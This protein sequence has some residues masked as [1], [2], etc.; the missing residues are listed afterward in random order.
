ME[1]EQKSEPLILWWNSDSG[2]FE[3]TKSK[4]TEGVFLEMNDENRL[5]LFSYSDGTSLIIRRTAMRR[6][7]EIAKVGYVHNGA[8]KGVEYELKEITEEDLPESLKQAQ[9]AW[10]ERKKEQE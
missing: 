8:R 5:W 9:R 6:A 2:S 7:N 3:P 1:D 10:Y 4:A